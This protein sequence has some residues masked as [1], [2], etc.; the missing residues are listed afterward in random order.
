MFSRVKENLHNSDGNAGIL[1]D[2]RP[3]AQ[4]TWDGQQRSVILALHEQVE[5][6]QAQ[7]TKQVR[8]GSVHCIH[9][10]CSTLS[11]NGATTCAAKLGNPYLAGVRL[12]RNM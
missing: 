11:R 10:C 9:S 6:L 12:Q 5:V 2:V 8:F 1:T 3:R 4:Q 7:L